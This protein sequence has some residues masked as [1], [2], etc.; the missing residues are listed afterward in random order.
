MARVPSESQMQIS[1]F[2]YEIIQE[3]ES[4]NIANRDDRIKDIARRQQRLCQEQIERSEK[5]FK[6]MSW[7]VIILIGT[8]ICILLI[9]FLAMAMGYGIMQNEH[10][11]HHLFENTNVPAIILVTG[12]MLDTTYSLSQKKEMYIMDWISDL[13][14]Y[15]G[16]RPVN[17]TD[18]VCNKKYIGSLVYTTIYGLMSTFAFAPFADPTLQNSSQDVL[19]R[20]VLSCI[21][22]IC[23]GIDMCYISLFVANDTAI[24]N[25]IKD[26]I[27]QYIAFLKGIFILMVIVNFNAD[28][29][30]VS[31]HDPEFKYKTYI[32]ANISSFD[33]T[34]VDE[35]T[36]FHQFKQMSRFFV[37]FNL[38]LGRD[39]LTYVNIIVV[40]I[41]I[42]QIK[43]LML[44]KSYTP[45]DDSL[46]TTV[47]DYIIKY[48]CHLVSAFACFQLV[49]PRDRREQHVWIEKTGQAC[50]VLLI[51][52]AIVIICNIIKNVKLFKIRTEEYGATAPIYQ[53]IIT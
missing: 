3:M 6:E 36:D 14:G 47:I 5:S 19:I 50:G 8:I 16:R 9:L 18:N 34:D 31:Q 21:G 24:S 15:T 39:A 48:L 32:P 7:V 37:P 51:P 29:W 22:T 10:D 41:Q 49:I 26:R 30:D 2:E 12:M 28:I 46:K 4:G 43:L 25:G 44:R 27:M 42:M 20:E 40:T 52:L 23:M 11:N 13:F 1:N 53:S 17:I 35:G 38:K 45:L 33:I